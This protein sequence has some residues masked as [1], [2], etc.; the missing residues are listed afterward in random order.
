LLTLSKQNE[1]SIDWHPDIQQKW[2]NESQ[3]GMFNSCICYPILIYLS[4]GFVSDGITDLD[5]IFFNF[6][7]NRQHLEKSQIIP[8]LTKDLASDGHP[9]KRTKFG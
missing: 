1:Y 5:E 4:L 9:S 3:E 7:K 8:R 6:Q 2:S